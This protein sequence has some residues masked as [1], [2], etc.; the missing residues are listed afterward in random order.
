MIKQVELRNFKQFNSQVFNIHSQGVSLIVGGNNSGKSTLLEALAVWEYAKTILI[1]YKGR[2]V[3]NNGV[4]SEGY[5]ISIEEFT[6]INIP[7]FRCLW[8]NN[9][10]I[11]GYS[12]SIKCIW[13]DNDHNEKY[14]Q[15]GFAL[16]QARLFVKQI[17]SNLS[18]GDIIPRCAYL[19]TFAGINR[20]EQWCSRAA[21]MK[22]IG[23]GLAGSILR[24]QLIEMNEQYIRKKEKLLEGRKKLRLSDWRILDGMHLSQLNAVLFSV[25]KGIIIPKKFDPIFNTK[26]EV[27]FVKGEYKGHRFLPFPGYSSRDIM[28]EGR[29]FL[30]WLSVYTYALSEDVDVLLLDEPDAHLYR[31]LQYELVQQLQKLLGDTGKQVLLA[32]HSIEIIQEF[33]YANIMAIERGHRCNYLPNETSKKRLLQGLGT[34]Y[35]PLL[36]RIRQYK[37]IIFA[38]NESDIKVLKIVANCF[39]HSIPNHI[40]E[41]GMSN[42]Y[43]ER[44]AIFIALA[45]DIAGLKAISINDRDDEDYTST[46]SNLSDRTA[47]RIWQGNNSEIRFRKWRRWELESYF[48]IPNTIARIA[49][50]KD[51]S[52]T[53]EQFTI[54]IIDDLRNLYGIDYNEDS[55]LLSDK[56][57]TNEGFFSCD[58][59][60]VLS[61]LCEKYKISNGMF[62]IAREM[63]S[64]EVCADLR[65]LI[66]EIETFLS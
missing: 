53:T 66:N 61:Q 20:N 24:N 63:N 25:F 42:N 4:R 22:S 9:K 59:K 35:F 14:L 28:V 56:Q 13:N 21:R 62:D 64:T 7:S 26:V 65:T 19:P 18:H 40:V 2:R 49:N 58:G 60:E 54:E 52:K 30:Q 1:H 38:E 47:R 57:A 43:K 11:G 33:Y 36:D 37:R 39:G 3:L 48:I 8:T 41:W 12:M 45:S 16:N 29:G 51:P 34:E 55:Y 5:G 46:Q 15:I 6:P 10:A 44:K 27:E 23:Q 17:S 31:T 50:R 32:T